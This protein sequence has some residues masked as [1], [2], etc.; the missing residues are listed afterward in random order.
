MMAASRPCGIVA[1]TDARVQVS[2]PHEFGNWADS[3]AADADWR[4]SAS[5]LG[6]ATWRSSAGT[7]Q[8]DQE[9][10]GDV[11]CESRLSR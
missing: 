6:S 9:G 7:R 4:E 1:T 11:M 5:L 8:C 2:G 3:V 10:D